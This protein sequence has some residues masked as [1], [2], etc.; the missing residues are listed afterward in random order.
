MN[1]LKER[2]A[3]ITGASQG[4]GKAIAQ[5]YLHEGANI[6]IGARN[7]ELLEQTK[8]ELINRGSKGQ[9]IYAEVLDVSKS[10]EVTSF[11]N[12]V[13]S[14]FPRLDILVNNAG[15]YGP[16]GNSEDVIWEEWVNTISINL[17]GVVLMCRAVMSHFKKNRYGKI[18]NLSGGGATKPMPRI[19]AYAASKAAVVRFSETLAEE[20]REFGIDVNLIAPGA[21]NTKMMDEILEAGPEKVG[22]EYYRKTL[23]Q[24]DSGGEPLEKGANLAVFLGSSASDGIT[25]K[26][27]SAIWDPWDQLPEHREELSRSDIYTLRRIVP[28]DRGYAWGER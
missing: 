13:F 17:F 27:I 6:F 5:T 4:L 12:E 2:Y 18:I 16:K 1:T 26:L 15:I 25:G 22:E 19:S 3:V 21:L 10:D 11:F 7:R 9:R 23:L 8:K 20:V 24:R 14:K 28:K